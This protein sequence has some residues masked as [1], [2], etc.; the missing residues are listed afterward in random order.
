MDTKVHEKLFGKSAT[1]LQ[2][3]ARASV[4]AASPAAA[5]PSPTAAATAATA[6]LQPCST[7]QSHY[8]TGRKY[9]ICKF[10]SLRKYKNST[11]YLL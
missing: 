1:L 10:I 3:A 6:S 5:P 11:L 2:A 8:V 7:S 4:G 9:S